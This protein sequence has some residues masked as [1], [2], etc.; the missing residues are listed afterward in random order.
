MDRSNL[1]RFGP[2]GT[3]ITFK[4][5]TLEIPR[6]LASIGLNAFEYQAVRRIQVNMEAQTKLGVEAD[7]YN[8]WLS[9]HA[10]YA[11]NLS[12]EDPKVLE[13]SK[14][15]LVLSLKAASYM[16]AH[17]VVFHPG[18]Y[19]RLDRREALKLCIQ[20]LKEVVQ[21]V[22][23]EGV[24][25]VFLGPETTGKLSQVGDL[26]EVLTMCEEVEMLRP[27]IDWAHIHARSRGGINSKDDYLK[28]LTE[29]ERRLGSFKHLHCHYTPVEFGSTGE[30]KHHTM[31]EAG[32]G[33]PFE[34]LAQIIAEQGL[35]L[36]II[37]ETPALEMDSLKMKEVLTQAY[38]SRK[39]S[40]L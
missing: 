35:S 24:K 38:L 14:Q 18:Y 29:V 13:G 4:G 23:S 11:V 25:D 36:I 34:P 28:V 33:P 5:D 32:F 17:Q 8:V 22:K 19:G 27:T 30:R 37:S 16:K 15:R 3:P 12:S 7:K 21:T 2:A 20:A 6:F 10:P 26:E 9:L 39:K 40:R 1:C 31:S